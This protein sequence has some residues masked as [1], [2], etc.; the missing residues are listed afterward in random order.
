MEDIVQIKYALDTFYFL[1]CAVLVMWMACGFAMLEAGLVRTKSTTEILAKNIALFAIASVMYLLVGYYIM[2]SSDGGVFPSFGML[3]GEE[4]SL[5]EV[6]AGGDDAPYYSSRADFFFQIVFAGACMSIVSGAV[7]ERMRLWAFLGFAV[8]MTGFIYPIQGAW[9]WGG[10]WLSELGYSDYAGSGI[11]HMAGA[12]AA[13]AGVLLLGPRR[14][15]YG[16]NGQINAIPGSNMPLSTLGIFILWMGWFGFNGG[17]ELKISDVESANNVAQVMVNTN[18]AAAGGL[19][20]AMLAARLL[21]GK[22][23]LTM[24]LNGALAGLVAITADPLSPSALGAVLIGGV[25]GLIVVFSVLGLDRL[26]ID[27]PA[28]AISAHGSAGIW[29]VLAVPLSNAEASFGAQ[30]IGVVSIFAWVFIVSLVVWGIIKAVVGIRISAEEEYLG[31][32]AVE[33]G[34][35]AY[36]EFTLKK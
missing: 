5:A 15:K 19:L 9:S 34:L 33:C 4:N 31:V 7:A 1:V 11:V 28:G 2:Y 16:P 3:I 21:F 14:G 26:K 12:T 22:T 6:T 27:D 25:G 13:L 35:E 29:G 17:S 23:D 32:D 36:P 30:L 20:G 10:G 8:L 18:L 24:I